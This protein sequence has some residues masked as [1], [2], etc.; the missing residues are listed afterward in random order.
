MPPV[1]PYIP[2]RITVHLGTPTSDAENVTVSFP[3]Y[4]KNV[5]GNGT[6]DFYREINPSLNT[7]ERLAGINALLSQIG[8][9]CGFSNGYFVFNEKTSPNRLLSALS[10][11]TVKADRRAGRQL[12]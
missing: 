4:V 10:L 7:T 3:D 8:F 6:D 1:T 12:R 5:Y 11:R 9:K 2:Q